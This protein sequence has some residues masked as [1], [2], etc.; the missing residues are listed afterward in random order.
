VGLAPGYLIGGVAANFD[1]TASL[2]GGAGAGGLFVI[3][4]DEYDTAFF[5][6]RAKFVHYRPRTLVLNNLEYDHAD[7]YPDLAAIQ[8]Q[9]N[10]LLR[11]V[12]PS[13]RI[14]VNGVDANLAATLAAGCWTPR[15]T[16]SLPADDGS[17]VGADWTASVVPESASRRFIV[18]HQGREVGTVNWSLL[19]THNVQN[20]LAA[21]GAAAHV[22]VLPE[23]AVLA[24]NGFRGVKRRMELRGIVAGVTVYDDFAHHP[25]AIETTLRGL[26]AEVGAARIVAVLESR[27]NTMRL[28]VHRDQL[29]H[30]L[31]L[32][33]LCWF[34]NPDNL[35]WDLPAAVASLGERARFAATVDGVVAGLA[36]ELRAGDHVL[37]MSNG[38]F[39]GLHEKLLA[40]LRAR[41]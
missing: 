10:Q 15:E 1:G 3:E 12:P 18:Q 20:A 9:F 5:D 13:G 7:I 39:G 31:A 34:Y 29:A 37:V 22:G 2:G 40:A 41:P 8:R 36:E 4:A 30:S 24:L 26:R 6:K 21:I 27:S 16:F 28:G 25:T 19:G 38:G 35:G 11:T 14:L 23:R 32:A 17:G 33:D